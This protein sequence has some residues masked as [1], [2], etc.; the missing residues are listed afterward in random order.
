MKRMENIRF[1]EKT[2]ELDKIKEHITGMAVSELGR[3]N[4]SNIHPLHDVDM[5]EKYLRLDVEFKEVIQVESNFPIHGLSDTLSLLDRNKSGFLSPGELIRIKENFE[6]AK[7]VK[8]FVNTRKENYP[9]IHSYSSRITV[10]EGLIELISKSIDDTGAVKDSAS[11]QLKS[12]RR[13]ISEKS[14]HLKKSLGKILESLSKVHYTRDEIITIKEGRY[15]IPIKEGQKRKVRGIIH[16]ESSSGETVFIEPLEI[17]EQN[18]FISQL[19][20]EEEIEIKKILRHITSELLKQREKIVLNQEILGIIDEHFARGQFAIKVNGNAPAITDKHELYIRE[21]RHPLLLLRYGEKKTVVPLDLKLGDEFNVLLITGPNAGGKTVALKTIGLLSLMVQC[22]IP[23]P[24]HPDSYFPVSRRI[25]ADI[26]DPQSIEMDLSTF[27][28]HIHNIISI[29]K[30]LGRED[31]I[32]IDEIGTG[33][34]PEEGSSLAISILE[35]LIESGCLS[36]ATTHHGK[37]KS[38]ALE[39][40]GIENASM[41]FDEES[42]FPSYELKVGVPGSSYAFEISRK[43]GLPE[44]IINRAI[45]NLGKKEF[46]LENIIRDLEKK[47][48][49]YEKELGDISI[50]RTELDG[51]RKLYGEKKEQLDRNMKEYIGKALDESEDIVGR[52]NALI[53]KVVK[54]IKESQATREVVKKSRKRINKFKDE[55][56]EKKEKIKRLGEEAP[57][58]GYRFRVDQ[59]VRIKKFNKTGFIVSLNENARKAKVRMENVTIDVDVKD[60]EPVAEEEKEIKKDK[61]VPVSVDDRLDLRGLYAYDAIRELDHYLDDAYAGGLNTVR[62][63]HGKGMGV[64]REEV[65]KFLAKDSRV[66]SYRL[67]ERHEGDTGVTIIELKTEE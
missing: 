67:G 47:V 36:V 32:L 52:A 4:I 55:L 33:T 64:L 58:A 10:P 62:I 38:F 49:K 42:L 48:K 12:I 43:L 11:K 5:I 1:T 63:I 19:R 30:E 23:V 34:D 17:L 18:N 15:V 7:Q 65:Q 61:I 45:E 9:G 27:S 46:K 16:H 41:S 44:D 54:E 59:K 2:L 35:K 25:I 60:L 40:Q 13:R 57:E 56:K 50:K 22:G 26:G 51:L 29:I 8:S 37:L 21:G 24:V 6:I 31:L 53:E 66:K 14:E 3:E 20:I 39:T 28:A